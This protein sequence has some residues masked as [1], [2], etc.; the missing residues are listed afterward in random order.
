MP[1]LFE[2]IAINKRRKNLKWKESLT[3]QKVCLRSYRSTG[4]T[5]LENR[6]IEE[7]APRMH[8]IEDRSMQND[9]VHLSQFIVVL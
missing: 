2:D 5:A 8:C 4:E 6:P 9:R 7:R 3:R 1:K